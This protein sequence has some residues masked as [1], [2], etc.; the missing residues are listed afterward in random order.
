MKYFDGHDQAALLPR[1][2]R[3]VLDSEGEPVLELS[4][5]WYDGGPGCP[6][7]LARLLRRVPAVWREHWTRR[8]Y[9][10]A[11]AQRE[12]CRAASRLFEPWQCA[13]TADVTRNG[14]GLLCVCWQAVQ[15]PFSGPAAR[16]VHTL[17]WD[18]E[19]GCVR[20]PG[21]FFPRGRLPRQARPPRG[22]LR[23]ARPVLVEGDGLFLLCP[24]Q[25]DWH[26]WPRISLGALPGREPPA[27]SPEKE[28]A[29]PERR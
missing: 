26:G 10:A 16:A 18:L 13:L 4:L 11:C 27:Q 25:G 23:R 2:E 28:N 15:R 29:P 9:P 20:T 7:P 24:E 5:D 8:A 22:A 19:Q 17:V 14:G 3:R 6:R 1:Q 21:S 12:Q